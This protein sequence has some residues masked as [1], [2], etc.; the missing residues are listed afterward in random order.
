MGEVPWVDCNCGRRNTAT[1]PCP[2]CGSGEELE[3]VT[4]HEPHV[5]QGYHIDINECFRHSD[6]D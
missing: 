6:E 4:E 5:A 1:D 2:H 3:Y